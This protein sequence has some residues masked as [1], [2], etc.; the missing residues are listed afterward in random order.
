MSEERPP[1]ILG[2][3]PR[4]RPHRRSNKRRAVSA[5]AASG[6][7]SAPN[8]ASKRN[9][10]AKPRRATARS[11][12]L[13][14]P[15]QPGGTPPRPPKRAPRSPSSGAPLKPPATRRGD[16]VSTAVHAAAELT[17]IGLS[18]SARVLRG[19]LGRLPRP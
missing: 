2:S 17:E 5:T 8:A 19:A 15:K 16:V 14:Q 11:Q 4:T 7:D 10:S 9:A 6:T 1:E 12:T 18:L 13:R 3:L